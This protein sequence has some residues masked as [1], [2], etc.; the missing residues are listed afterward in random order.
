MN[1]LPFGKLKAHRA[2]TFVPED[3]DLGDWTK[4]AP[5]FDHLEAAA[6]RAKSAVELERW[7][8]D[9]SE[10]SAVL[11]EEASRRN[12]A[13]TCHTDHTEAEQAY[14]FFVEKI[15]PELK[16]RQFTLEKLYVAHPARTEL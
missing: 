15:E 12:I 4:I 9:W 1:L 3:L 16:P 6:G 14:L 10:L 11:E 5:L 13:M 7:L 8:M 2:R